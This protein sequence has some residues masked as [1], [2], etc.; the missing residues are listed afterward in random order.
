MIDSLQCSGRSSRTGTVQY[1][2][3]D[4]DRRSNFRRRLVAVEW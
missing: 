2:F 4:L 1:N 3:L